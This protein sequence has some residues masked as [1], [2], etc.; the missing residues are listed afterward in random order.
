M[1]APC[2]LLASGASDLFYD[3]Q[4]EIIHRSTEDR[5]AET[6][7]RIREFRSKE[8]E[9]RRLAKLADDPVEQ[10][11]H[12]KEAKKWGQRA[13]NEHD[14]FTAEKKALKAEGARLLELIE[15]SL[16]GKKSERRLFAAEWSVVE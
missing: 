9:E 12:K 13:D 16:R 11:K 6:E 14:S 10:P 1:L 4:E 15:Q 8:K 3:Q 2:G 7:A 5:R